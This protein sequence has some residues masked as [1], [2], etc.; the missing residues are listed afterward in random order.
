M[1]TKIGYQTIE[2]YP[3]FR[4]AILIS[5]VCTKV[6]LT[7]SPLSRRAPCGIRRDR[8]TCMPYPRRQRSSWARIKL[9][10]LEY[11][12]IY[13]FILIYE[14]VYYLLFV[15]SRLLL[16]I[17]TTKKILIILLIYLIFKLLSGFFHTY[18]Y[19]ERRVLVK[20]KKQC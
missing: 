18:H 14:F 4:M 11:S 12:L 15:Y 9:S 16:K 20:Y 10:K 1:W 6:L 19:R 3:L 2:Y 5:R 13:K 17:G 8:S 7:R